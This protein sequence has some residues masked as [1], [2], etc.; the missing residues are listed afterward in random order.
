MPPPRKCRSTVSALCALL[1]CSAAICQMIMSM[2]LS[3]WTNKWW[4]WWIQYNNTKSTDCYFILF[5]CK[6]PNHSTEQ[7]P[8]RHSTWSV[9]S[10]FTLCDI[11]LSV[12]RGHHL[13][14]LDT[15]VSFDLF[16]F[17]CFVNSERE[18]CTT[19]RKLKYHQRRR[20]HIKLWI[21]LVR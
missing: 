17:S 21:H 7:T 18:G 13:D 9:V 6:W 19:D 3:V 1:S 4:W 12:A 5:Y 15:C 8:R 10:T 2:W 16:S 11:L 20:V 14:P